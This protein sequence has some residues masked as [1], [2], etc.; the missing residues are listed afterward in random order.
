MQRLRWL[1]IGVVLVA[2]VGLVVFLANWEIPP[3]SAPVNKAIPHDAQR[4]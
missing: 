2:L 4:K 1:L 3:P